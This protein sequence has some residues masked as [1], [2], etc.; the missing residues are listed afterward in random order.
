MIRNN[1]VFTFRQDTVE[2]VSV[3]QSFL[4]PIESTHPVLWKTL[5]S[6]QLSTQSKALRLQKH[7]LDHL[8]LPE[9]RFPQCPKA[10]IQSWSQTKPDPSSVSRLEPSAQSDLQS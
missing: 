7:L 9:D 3:D 5:Q 10:S 2:V 1:V 6:E 8:L 4:P